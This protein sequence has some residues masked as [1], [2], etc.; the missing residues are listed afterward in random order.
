MNI[1]ILRSLCTCTSNSENEWLFSHILTGTQACHVKTNRPKLLHWFRANICRMDINM[2]KLR[3]VIWEADISTEDQWKT[4]GCYILTHTLL[5]FPTHLLTCLS[6]HFLTAT[7][8]G[9][10]PE[11]EI[12]QWM[13]VLWCRWCLAVQSSGCCCRALVWERANEFTARVVLINY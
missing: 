13:L 12:I 1:T 4:P 3:R 6:L 11:T 7:L 9:L 5:Y 2:L 8:N 10:T